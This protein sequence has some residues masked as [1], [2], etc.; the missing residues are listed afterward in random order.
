MSL[1]EIPIESLPSLRDKFRVGWPKHI[2]AFDLLDTFVKRHSKY[3]EGFKQGKFLSLNGDWESDGT[4]ITILVR[5]D[6]ISLR[7]S[8]NKMYLFTARECSYVCDARRNPR[9]SQDST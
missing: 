9:K 7:L 8:D 2:I 5:E 4:F 6:E 3:P 1:V